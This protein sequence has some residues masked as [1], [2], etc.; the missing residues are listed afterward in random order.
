[1]AAAGVRLDSQGLLAA[2]RV[3]E[4]HGQAAAAARVRR[5][6]HDPSGL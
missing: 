2:T 1:M 6:R 5:Q 4:A 3:L